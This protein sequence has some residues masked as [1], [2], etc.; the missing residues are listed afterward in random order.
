MSAWPSVHL[1]Q[2][3][4]HAP[5]QNETHQATAIDSPN[6]LHI[7]VEPVRNYL[8]DSRAILFQ[9]PI[10]CCAPDGRKRGNASPQM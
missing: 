6:L 7:L 2:T 8:S 9:H 10:A 4:T 1:C 3:R 5:Q